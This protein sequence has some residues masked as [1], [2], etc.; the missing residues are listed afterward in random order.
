MLRGSAAEAWCG[1]S[2]GSATTVRPKRC[3][4]QSQFRALHF[5]WDA[6]FALGCRRRGRAPSRRPRYGGGGRGI[7]ELSVAGGRRGAGGLAKW[8]E[9]DWPPMPTSLAFAGSDAQQ[10]PTVATGPK[11]AAG[12]SGGDRAGFVDG[13]ICDAVRRAVAACQGWWR[14]DSGGRGG[15]AM[16]STKPTAPTDSA[17]QRADIICR[18]EWDW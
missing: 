15:D 9:R 16:R 18:W 3:W 5:A 1:G 4:R 7:Q 2:H 12:E 13:A 14:D 10:G 11:A 17:S 6:L 8:R